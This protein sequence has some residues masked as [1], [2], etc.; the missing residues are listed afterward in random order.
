MC[1]CVC[2]VYYACVFTSYCG[3]SGQLTWLL[4]VWCPTIINNSAIYI[5]LSL[6]LL[7]FVQININNKYEFSASVG[8][9]S[10]SVDIYWLYVCA[11]IHADV[12][13]FVFHSLLNKLRTTIIII[14]IAKELQCRI[15][16]GRPAYGRERGVKKNV[17]PE[18]LDLCTRTPILKTEYALVI[19]HSSYI[20]FYFLLI[21]L[22]H[23]VHVES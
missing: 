8:G 23:Y 6:L 16:C 9:V 20:F 19:H 15:G 4:R 21:V 17:Y 10:R 7:F 18:C 12:R 22:L 2:F 3:R 5:S 1:V 14:T 13:K 11:I